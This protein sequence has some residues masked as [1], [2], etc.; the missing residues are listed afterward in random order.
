MA[1]KRYKLLEGVGQ[2]HMLHLQTASPDLQNGLMEIMHRA[3]VLLTLTNGLRCL[4][5]LKQ[6]R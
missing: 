4:K 1:S 5:H 6:P 2:A 3:A